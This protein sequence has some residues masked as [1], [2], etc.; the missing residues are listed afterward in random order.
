MMK[1]ETICDDH[2]WLSVKTRSLFCSFH[3]EP[4]VVPQQVVSDSRAHILLQEGASI[5]SA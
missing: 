5:S 4:A 2:I 3:H 1:N